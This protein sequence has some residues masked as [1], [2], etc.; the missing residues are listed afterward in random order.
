MASDITLYKEKNCLYFKKVKSK[1]EIVLGIDGVLIDTQGN[2]KEARK[3]VDFLKGK[4]TLIAIVGHNNSFNRRV[5]ETMKI[6]YFV[7]PEALEKKDSLKQ[8][9]SGINHV[10]AKIAAKNGISFVFDINEL[11][12]LGPTE[13]AARFARII[14]NIKIARKANC[15]IKIASFASNESEFVKSRD[16]E[17]FLLTLGA[18][19]QQMKESTRF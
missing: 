2:E 14:Q 15:R 18:S 1:E 7:S 6:N 11:R 16:R 5:I 13:K 17:E 3:I 8:R 4:D 12:S 10:T 9:D 19:T